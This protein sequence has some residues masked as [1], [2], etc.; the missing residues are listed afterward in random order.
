MTELNN[1]VVV[2]GPVGCG[3]TTNAKALANAFGVSKIVD[4]YSYTGDNFEPKDTLY[5][6]TYVPMKLFTW[7]SRLTSDN[8]VQILTFSRAMELAN[9]VNNRRNTPTVPT[10]RPPRKPP[11]KLQTRTRKRNWE[12][13]MLRGACDNL[14]RLLKRN[15]YEEAT[16][17]I[18]LA[19]NQCV[20]DLK[21]EQLRDSAT[22][23]KP[24]S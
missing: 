1:S 21:A 17:Y 20:A 16:S 7:L 11:T 22:N 13:R 8:T 9:L 2:I 15:N 23:R 3:K 24:K 10:S 4:G 5:L 12:I 18:H 6:T 14:C 19:V